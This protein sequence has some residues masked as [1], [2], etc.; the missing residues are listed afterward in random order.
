MDIVR[1]NTAGRVD[2]VL[3][4]EFNNSAVSV[5]FIDSFFG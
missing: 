5:V 3:I 4:D 2:D 1:I